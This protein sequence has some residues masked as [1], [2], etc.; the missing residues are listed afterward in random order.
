MEGR[1]LEADRGFDAAAAQAVQAVPFQFGALLVI[2]QRRQ[3][4]GQALGV[5]GAA[6]AGGEQAGC[7][8][9]EDVGRFWFCAMLLFLLAV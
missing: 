8:Q 3:C 5:E 6:G 7:E 1:L 2:M 4:V 9:G